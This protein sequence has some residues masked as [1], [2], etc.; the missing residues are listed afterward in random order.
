MLGRSSTHKWIHQTLTHKWKIKSL[1]RIAKHRIQQHESKV[2]NV[3]VN[4][5]LAYTKCITNAHSSNKSFHKCISSI[6]IFPLM[7]LG[8]K[9]WEYKTLLWLCIF[10]SQEQNGPYIVA[11]S[12][13][14]CHYHVSVNMCC[15]LVNMWA[16]LLWT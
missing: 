8:T 10:T 16:S 3:K 14:H 2:Q 7:L 5:T 11:S 13:S 12:I 9:Q 4:K 1:K 6:D 15:G